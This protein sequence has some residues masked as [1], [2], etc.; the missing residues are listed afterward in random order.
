MSRR[1]AMRRARNEERATV[2]RWRVS[3]LRA[4]Q[5]ARN[6]IHSRRFNARR[7]LQSEALDA[8]LAQLELLHLT[9]H[10]G[11]VL[12]DE[13]HIARDLVMGDLASAK[14]L[15]LILRRGRLRLEPDPGTRLLA[16]A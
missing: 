10:R 2:S 7:T 1:H 15:D 3:R 14:C 16:E 5:R 8:H 12:V 9:R 4:M 6:E 11:R 13:R